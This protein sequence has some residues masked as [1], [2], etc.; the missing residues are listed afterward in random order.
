VSNNSLAIIPVRSLTTGKTR[1]AS[2]V[3]TET[4][5]ELTE[6]MLAITLSACRTSTVIDQILVISPDI[7]ALA[8]AYALDH[9]VIAVRQ[10]QD[11]PGL[12][13]ALDQARRVSIVNQF[14]TTVVLFADLPLVNGDDVAE[15][16]ST[17]GQIVIAPDQN[18]IGTNGLLLRRGEVDLSDFTFR[19]GTASFGA[20]V[21]ESKRLGID[22]A[23]VEIAGLGFDLDTPDDLGNLVTLDVGFMSR[24]RKTGS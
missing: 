22:P 16:V 21:E 14:E 5:R 20:H 17:P 15:F 7:D 4:R 18:R 12:I 8:F 9:E 19:F 3:N 11:R 6:R 2:A 10:S 1:L 24:L 13:P 23:I